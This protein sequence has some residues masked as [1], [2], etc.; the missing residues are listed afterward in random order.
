MVWNQH[1]SV[2]NTGTHRCYWKLQF[3]HTPFP[4]PASPSALL[5]LFHQALHCS[6]HHLCN[7]SHFTSNYLAGIWPLHSPLQHCSR[8]S[9]FPI[10]ATEFTTE[11]YLFK[12]F[13][14]IAQSHGTTR[15]LIH[16]VK[17]MRNY[18]RICI[19]IF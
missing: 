14:A 6:L 11:K 12:M 2:Y 8:E 9:Q 15:V 1:L 5:P 17:T 10:S 16:H 4:A 13:C 7:N 18:P 19:L 3:Q